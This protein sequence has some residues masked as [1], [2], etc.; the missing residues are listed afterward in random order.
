MAGIC[1]ALCSLFACAGAAADSNAD[2]V[3]YPGSVPD[4]IQ[5]SMRPNFTIAAKFLR[6]AVAGDNA[7]M[8]ALFYIPKVDASN[9]NNA[10]P[11]LDSAGFI[12]RYQG[13][14]AIS[15]LEYSLYSQR[16][17]E[18][19]AFVGG[20]SY[21]SDTSAVRVEFD[22]KQKDNQWYVQTLKS[23]FLPPQKK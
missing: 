3:L 15:K 1:F 10:V 4:D 5:K 9:R 2:Y 20:Y 22:E 16:P 17:D 13:H 7:A 11:K 14:G 23:Q 21:Y 6:S 18:S 19:Y 8:Q 12:K